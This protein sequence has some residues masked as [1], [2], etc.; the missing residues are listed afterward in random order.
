MTTDIEYPVEKIRQW[1]SEGRT[2]QSIAQELAAT[3]DPRVTPKLIYKV[4][5]KHGIK[6][7]RTGPRAAE[8]H[9]EWKGGRIV[10][11]LGYLKVYCPDH[12]TCARVNGL[13]LAKANGGYYRKQ[14]YVWEHRLVAERQLGRYL[15]PNEVV[16]H[17]NGNKQDNRPENLIVFQSNAD[18]LAHDLRGK[19]PKWTE[20]G[21]AAI[22]QSALRRSARARLRKKLG[23]SWPQKTVRRLIALPQPS[24]QVPS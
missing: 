11:K 9:P 1:I 15:N 22:R 20:D 21:K 5:K 17:V 18:H 3:T 4:C 19:C 8:G 16:H 13:R 6:C 12:P 24:L 7:Q 14:R 10:S 2:Q 23:E